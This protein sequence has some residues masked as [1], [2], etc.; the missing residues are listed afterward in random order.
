[1]Q[2]CS[3]LHSCQPC[4]GP[5]FA[6][7]WAIASLQACCLMCAVLCCAVPR[8]DVL[9][10]AALRCIGLCC[11]L[12]HTSGSAALLCACCSQGRKLVSIVILPLLP[13]RPQSESSVHLCLWA[14]HACCHLPCCCILSKETRSKHAQMRRDWLQ[15]IMQPFWG[16]SILLCTT[17]LW[18][19]PHKSPEGLPFF[20]KHKGMCVGN[21]SG[22]V[23]MHDACLCLHCPEMAVTANV[24]QP[25]C[26]LLSSDWLRLLRML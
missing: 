25:D 4:S 24:S 1:M 19:A 20:N 21:C 7:P 15:A 16:W 6:P 18:R 14:R 13:Y 12:R 3:R 17:R 10:C 11:M 2:C 22:S 26:H 8:C 23:K 9:C 5:S